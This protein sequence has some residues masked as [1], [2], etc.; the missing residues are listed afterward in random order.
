[1]RA[2][3]ESVRSCIFYDRCGTSRVIRGASTK[4]EEEEE[5]L[6]IQLA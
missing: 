1:M 3:L 6:I 4:E 2:S 5:M